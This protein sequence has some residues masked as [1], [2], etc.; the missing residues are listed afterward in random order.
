MK[1][2]FYLL[3]FFA[4]LRSL[5]AD[6]VRSPDIR[7]LGMGENGVTQSAF[8]N[9]ALVVLDHYKKLHL[10]YWNRYRLKE[11]GTVGLGFVCPN[12]LLSFGIHLSSFGYDAYRETLFRLSAGKQLN[13]YWMIGISVQ[14]RL[15]QTELTEELPQRLS[16]DVGILY[17]PV[18]N[19]LIGVLIMDMPSFSLGNTKIE[20]KEITDYSLQ[21]G[22]QWKII[23][24]LLIAAS[25]SAD[26]VRSFTA[27]IGLEYMPCKNFFLRSGLQMVSVFPTMGLGYRLAGF[28]FDVAVSYHPVLGISSG[29]GL[30]YTF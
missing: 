7:S 29:C 18:E 25:F 1:G 26:K 14:Y 27:S 24:S 22:F 13:A 2:F 28:S 8:F 9:P 23:D 15:W 10:D 4:S 17:K 6:Y 20:N 5:A 11:L 19:L 30:N 3:L 12:P 16:T 21:V